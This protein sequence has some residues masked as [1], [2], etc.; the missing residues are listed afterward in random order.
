MRERESTVRAGLSD[1]W[2]RVAAVYLGAAAD[3]SNGGRSPRRRRLGLTAGAG[4]MAHERGMR[5][6]TE[7][8]SAVSPSAGIVPGDVPG[9]PS[10]SQTIMVPSL[11]RLLSV[12]P[13]DAPKTLY[14]SA[15][16]EEN[17]LGK[18][19]TSGREWAF[20][21][22]RRFYALDP[23]SLLFRA[24]RDLWRGDESGQR[25]LALLCAMA[26]DPV[27]RASSSVILSAEQGEAVYPHDFEAAIENAFPGAYKQNTRRTT[28]QKVASS[29]T[30]AGHLRA[31][32]PTRKVRAHVHPT[33]SA[34]AYALLLGH[35]QGARGHALFETLWTKIL[36]QQ[37]SRL[38]DLA[39]SASQAGMLE[40]RNAGGVVEIG[41]RE[42]LRPMEDEL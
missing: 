3:S 40:F 18:D 37:R 42:L 11:Q 29:W 10:T 36:D 13:S 7:T 8:T 26:R 16:M 1:E 31:E 17:I 34:V 15:V 20:R 30:Q 12:V 35:I 25:L 38:L 9:G 4:E 41:F 23:R 22:L 2:T 24:L 21:Q 33:E 39:T 6:M 14:R 32:K 5:T 19:T 27:L 28:A